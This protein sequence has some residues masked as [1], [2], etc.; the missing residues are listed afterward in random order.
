[1]A[2]CSVTSILVACAVPTKPATEAP[3]E[4]AATTRDAA[5]A[6]SPAQAGTFTVDFAREQAAKPEG[7]EPLFNGKDLAGWTN[8]NT[9]PSTW[10]VGKDEAGNPV[11]A[12]TGSPTGVMRTDRQYRNFVFE[13]EYSHRKPG[14]NAGLFVWSDAICARGVPFTLASRIAAIS[15]YLQPFSNESPKSLDQVQ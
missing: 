1:M 10:S 2:A 15:V 3:A 14:G 9:S 12:C 7:W 5:I 6:A 8:V 11:I 4:H 13:M